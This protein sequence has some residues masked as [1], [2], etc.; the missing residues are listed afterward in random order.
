M[1]MGPDRAQIRFKPI[2]KHP[3]VELQLKQTLE[4]MQEWLLVHEH[5]VLIYD[6][7]PH[8]DTWVYEQVLINR[9]SPSNF[10]NPI[11]TMIDGFM[12]LN[13]AKFIYVAPGMVKRYSASLPYFTE[14]QV[15][16]LLKRYDS[17]IK[18]TRTR[19]IKIY[20]EP[21]NLDTGI[22]MSIKLG[23]RP[24]VDRSS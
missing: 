1:A 5:D 10:W 16:F 11:Y 19:V 15:R 14:G 13:G 24:S 3:N 23:L 4:E 22:D 6:Q 18:N 2:K 12:T 8:P 17:F 20:S 7:F 9:P 21:F